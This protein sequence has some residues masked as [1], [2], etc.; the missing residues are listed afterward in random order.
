[1]EVLNAH[2]VIE[3]PYLRNTCSV[4]CITAQRRGTDRFGEGWIEEARKDFRDAD[5]V[6]ATELLAIEDDE[7][8]EPIDIDVLDLLNGLRKHPDERE[9]AATESGI[10]TRCVRY[11]AEKNHR[12]RISRIHELAQMLDA[13]DTPEPLTRAGTEDSKHDS[14]VSEPM[15]ASGDDVKYGSEMDDI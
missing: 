10:F 3:P 1:M 8:E 12:W 9:D 14:A 7:C 4:K 6:R 15:G 11:C 2:R 13:G 5:D